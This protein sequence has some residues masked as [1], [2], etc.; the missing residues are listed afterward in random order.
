MN[1]PRYAPAGL[2]VEQSHVRV[3]IDGG[4]GAEP[5]GPLIAWLVLTSAPN[6]SASYVGWRRMGSSRRS[7][8][9][10]PAG[11]R[12]RRGQSSTRPIRPTGTSSKLAATELPGRRN[13]LNFRRGLRAS[14]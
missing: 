7:V 10:T 1:S 5:T 4:P 9:F 13:S 14:T 6:S 2:L 11:L 12:S 3:A 8:R